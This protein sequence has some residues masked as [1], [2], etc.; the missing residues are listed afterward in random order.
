M[1]YIQSD[2]NTDVCVFC[3][4]M[5]RLDG[6]ENLIV[7][8]GPRAFIILNRYPY[9]TGHLMIVPNDHL[10][11]LEQLDAETR[12]EMMEL[13]AQSMV[14]LRGVYQRGGSTWH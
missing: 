2:K 4:E 12:A 3:N 10:A 9:T 1:E 7:Y 8:R 13:T 6:F 11:S 14:F 5:S